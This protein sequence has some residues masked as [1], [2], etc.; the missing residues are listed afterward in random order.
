MVVAEKNSYLPLATGPEPKK[1]SGWM[2][3]ALTFFLTMAVAS[4]FYIVARQIN[5]RFIMY[6]I[7]K[8]ANA[9]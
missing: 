6:S 9:P 2:R 3:H 5:V 8:L 7:Y 4:V 1:T